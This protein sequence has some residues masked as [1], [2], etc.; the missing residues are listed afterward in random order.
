MSSSVHTA[1]LLELLLA[2]RSILGFR[3][4]FLEGVWRCGVGMTEELSLSPKMSLSTFL[5]LRPASGVWADEDSS[6]VF[7]SY[8]DVPEG[9]T[10]PRG[11]SLLIFLLY[12]FMG[13]LN[14]YTLAL[15]AGLIRME[16]E[17]FF[18]EP[19]EKGQVDQEAEQGRVH[20]VYRRPPTPK[21]PPVGGPQALDT[22]K[23]SAE[24]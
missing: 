5:L 2:V 18:I 13:S 8:Q 17:E 11:P 6:A 15:Q 23:T 16:E 12:L 24:G 4:T 21:P 1:A 9:S 19:L 3:K 7:P 14:L 20:V 22:G 10:P